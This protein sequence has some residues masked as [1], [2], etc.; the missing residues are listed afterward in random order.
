MEDEAVLLPDGGWEQIF[1]ESPIANG[2]VVDHRFVRANPAL[3]QLIGLPLEQLLGRDGRDFL[4]PALA[5]DLVEGVEA[6]RRGERRIRLEGAVVRSDGASRWAVLDAV[7]VATPADGRVSTMVQ[8]IDLTDL[9]EARLSLSASERRFRNLLTNISDTVSLTDADGNIIYTTGRHN[10]ALGYTAAFWEGVHPLELVHP[11][12][13][14]RAVDAWQETLRRPGVEVT[15]EV[16]LRVADGSWAD[17]MATGSNLLADPDVGGLVLTTRNIT[18]I[19][20]AER[21]STSQAKVLELIGRSAPLAGILERCVQLV[22]DNGVGGRTSIYLLDGDRLEMRAGRAPDEL[23]EFVRHPPRLPARTLC[24]AAIE[25][26]RTVV[27]HDLGAEEVDPRL[28]EL[29]GRLDI[30]SGWSHPITS[31][32][33]T[34][35]GTI[36]T[37]FERPHTPDRHERQVGEVAANLVSIA[38]ER[39]ATED[40][41]AHQAMHDGL[42]G[43]PNR[44]LLMDRLGHALNRRARTRTDIAVLFCDLDRFKVVN[45]SLGHGVGDQLLV[46]VADRMRRAVDPGDTVA[47][48]GGDEFVVLVEDA[49]DADR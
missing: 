10:Q 20:R 28:R 31:A 48:F 36:S 2:I 17:V 47:R 1:F 41:L 30:R 45:D 27:V 38:L 44:T 7:V 40:R 11:E 19:R 25:S 3:C 32:S 22:E 37:I 9:H 5:A 23:N 39:V 12:D 33:G 15:V 29:G 8:A 49:D 14:Q 21:L 16:R 24:D 26:R 43:L 35:V 13:L 46:A 42:T 6:L 34:V 18:A 4:G